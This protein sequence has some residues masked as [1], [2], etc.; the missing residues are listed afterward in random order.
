MRN[1]IDISGK[2]F[3]RLVVLYQFYN[4]IK[5]RKRIFYKCVCDCGKNKNIS[6]DSLMSNKT[7][8]CGCIHKEMLKKTKTT[9]GFTASDGNRRRFYNIFNKMTARCDNPRNENYKDYGGRGIKCLW[10]SFEDFRNDVYESYQLHIKEFGEK[11][12]TIERKNNNGHYCKENCRWA[13]MKEQANNKRNNLFFT[14]AGETKSLA[15]WAN[16]Y[17]IKKSSLKYRIYIAGWSI[18]KALTSPKRVNQFR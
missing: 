1:F 9:H 5:D 16:E 8:S 12:T 15:I 7:Q 18:E 4:K 6:R 3:G 17:G 13:T 2:R 11:Q 10:K 14:F